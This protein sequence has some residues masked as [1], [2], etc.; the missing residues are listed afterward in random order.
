[1]LF[2]ILNLRGDRRENANK[3]RGRKEIATL[4]NVGRNN[5]KQTTGHFHY[6]IFEYKEP[7]FHNFTVVISQSITSAY[8][9]C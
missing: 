6:T 8:D 7:G 3:L 9:L 2:D 1:M 5:D 4:R